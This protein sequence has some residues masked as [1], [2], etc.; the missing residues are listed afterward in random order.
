MPG[1]ADVSTGVLPLG[2]WS[3]I[4]IVGKDV[5]VGEALKRAVEGLMERVNTLDVIGLYV[6][7]G[8]EVV[9]ALADE[10]VEGDDGTVVLGVVELED[11][12]LSPAASSSPFSGSSLSESSFSG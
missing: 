1:A 4:S 2:E 10:G 8:P 5:K 11:V 9:V 7:S 12:E 3:V 6:N